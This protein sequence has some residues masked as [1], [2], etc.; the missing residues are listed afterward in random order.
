M[1]HCV[2]LPVIS[3]VSVLALQMSRVA[4]FWMPGICNRDPIP[5]PAED[6]RFAVRS[7]RVAIGTSRT[8]QRYATDVPGRRSWRE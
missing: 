8:D 1:I 5:S 6:C 2:A 3:G 7:S 4:A